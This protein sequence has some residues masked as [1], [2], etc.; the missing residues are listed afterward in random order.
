MDD[1]GACVGVMALC[2]EDGTIH[3]FRAHQTVLA[4][5]GY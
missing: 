2:L 1:D 5:G 3:L 4:T